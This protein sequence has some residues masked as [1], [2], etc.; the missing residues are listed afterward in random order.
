MDKLREVFLK[1]LQYDRHFVELSKSENFW[2]KM[3]SDL[4]FAIKNY[5]KRKEQ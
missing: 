4:Y 1:Y 5:L 2:N 3:Y